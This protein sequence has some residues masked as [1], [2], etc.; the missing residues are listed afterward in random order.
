MA[1]GLDAH[2]VGWAGVVFSLTAMSLLV[3]AVV[4]VDHAR[5]IA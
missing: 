3:N 5:Q 2:L 1:A 4:G